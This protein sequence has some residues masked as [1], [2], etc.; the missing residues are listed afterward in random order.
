[1]LVL[2]EEEWPLRLMPEYGLRAVSG[3]TEGGGIAALARDGPSVK[4]LRLRL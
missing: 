2:N 3:A 4:L 1:M